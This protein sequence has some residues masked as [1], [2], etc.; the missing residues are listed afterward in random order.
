MDLD[1][2]NLSLFAQTATAGDMK[3]GDGIRNIATTL[4]DPFPN[5][6]YKV[7]D[8]EDMTRLVESVEL[9]G[10]VNPLL[11]RPMDGGRYQLV[12]GHRRLEAARRAGLD[13]VPCAVRDMDDDTATILM[14]DSN[15]AR[16]DIP[17]G[18]QARAMRMRHQALLHQG[19]KDEQGSTRQRIADETGVSGSTVARLVRLAT[20]DDRLLDAVDSGQLPVRAGLALTDTTPSQQ[21]VIADWIGPTDSHRRIGEEHAKAIA[22][23]ARTQDTLDPGTITL[24]KP[25]P[26]PKATQATDALNIPMTWLPATIQADERLAWIREAIRRYAQTMDDGEEETTA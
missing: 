22:L 23:T 1:L 12:S 15:L 3:P 11:V 16:T 24:L 5:H 9:N 7:L 14:V 6:P 17:V 2:K 10:I 4:I 20:L 18:Q 8:D 26:K 25:K 19:R 21:Q 13:T